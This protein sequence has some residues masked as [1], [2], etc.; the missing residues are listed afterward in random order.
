ME[1]MKLMFLLGKLKNSFGSLLKLNIHWWWYLEIPFPDI[2][3]W[4]IKTRAQKDLYKN[5]HDDIHNNPVLETT[6]IP[7]NRWMD[8]QFW[9]IYT[10][11]YCSAIKINELMIPTMTGMNFLKIK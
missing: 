1:Q 11:K 8:K 2:Y 9:Y 3:P 10:M 6:Q 7:N 5:V 4:K